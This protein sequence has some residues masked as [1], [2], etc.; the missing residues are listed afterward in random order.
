MDRSNISIDFA[1]QRLSPIA[2]GALYWPD[3]E[4]L[5][6][7]DLH[8]GKSTTFRRNGLPIPQGA[9]ESTIKRL[10]QDITLLQP[11][12]VFILGD[13]V[14]AR[15]SWDATLIESLKTLVGCIPQEVHLIL[16]NHDIGSRHRLSDLGIKIH[17]DAYQAD[18]FTLI[19]DASE[20][21]G[22]V[23]GEF[24]LAGHL[25]PAVRIGKSG[26]FVRARCFWQTNH[27][28][29][30]P[31]YGDFTGAKRIALQTGEQAF[32]IV[33]EQ[34]FTLKGSIALSH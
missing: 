17:E 29:T 31:A 18:P 6:V 21:N 32:A 8:L 33:E 25:H 30:L 20:I 24:H 3:R 9:T 1:G 2:S 15:C 7:A 4:I 13:L 11:K 5:F 14:H 28:L 12:Q 26:D 10:C 19:H 34:L 27:V 23:E 22:I 16:G